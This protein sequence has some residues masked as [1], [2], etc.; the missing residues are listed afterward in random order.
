MRAPT[1]GAGILVGQGGSQQSCLD[2]GMWGGEILCPSSRGGPEALREAG[3][4]QAL[5]ETAPLKRGPVEQLTKGPLSWATG[6]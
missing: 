4:V 1:W 6:L 2:V 3:F 5:P